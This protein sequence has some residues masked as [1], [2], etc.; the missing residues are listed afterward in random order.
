M[1]QLLPQNLKK[2]RYFLRDKT[3]LPLFLVHRKH[4]THSLLLV[5]LLVSAFE[6]WT[7]IMMSFAITEIEAQKQEQAKDFNQ[8]VNLIF[9]LFLHQK[10][11]EK[12]HRLNDPN[13]DEVNQGGR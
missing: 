13:L 9:L 3:S 4:D 2:G 12:D 11:P 5:S 10:D 8:E 7:S 6:S 1:L